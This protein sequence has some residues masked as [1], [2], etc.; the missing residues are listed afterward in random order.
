MENVKK[1]VEAGILCMIQG[2]GDLGASCHI[3]N[4]DIGLYDITD[5]HK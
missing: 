2:I 1:P 5:I 3:T 4:N